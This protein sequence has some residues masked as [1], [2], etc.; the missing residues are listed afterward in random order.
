ML[1]D[2]DLLG[3]RARLFSLLGDACG[4]TG[5]VLPRI[6]LDPVCGR[7][8]PSAGALFP[9]E[10]YLV[11]PAGETTPS[12]SY[13]S[14]VDANVM[15][16]VEA[17]DI[18][19][20]G[21]A[22][23]IPAP[24]GALLCALVVAVAR[25]WRSMRKY[26]DRGYLYTCLDVAHATASI[27][28]AAEAQ[29]FAPTIFLRIRRRALAHALGLS[30]HCR[31]PQVVLALS[32]DADATDRGGKGGASQRMPSVCNL[33]FY[34]AEPTDEFEQRAW[35]GLRAITCY[36]QDFPP[37]QV[38]RRHSSLAGRSPA[39]VG[40]DT[41][42]S[43]TLW[44]GLFEAAPL[45]FSARG[46]LP[47]PLSVDA[48]EGALRDLDADLLLDCA[49]FDARS[50]VSLSL[51]ARRIDGLEPGIYRLDPSGAMSRAVGGS[52]T[53]ASFSLACMNQSVVENAAGLVV[54]HA[55][56]R[57]VLARRGRSGLCEL[58]FHAGQVAH[59][60]CVAAARHD[61]GITCIGGFDEQLI[62]QAVWLQSEDDAIYVIAIG[63]ADPEAVKLDRAAIAYAHGAAQ[64]TL[65]WSRLS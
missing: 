56:V 45:R 38:I 23:G 40:A 10:L 52:D 47:E 54:L 65:Q 60:L 55:P 44:R 4:Q 17:P 19:A 25:P 12:T 31:E 53:P 64:S 36:H 43:E 30:D 22:A 39:P 18:G 32:A 63:K 29:R 26:G 1:S 11:L 46:F 15:R 62:A 20:L 57:E 5:Q 49:D 9:Y 28:A 50:G 37:P 34:H 6:G 7:A 61:F 48:L 2:E 58:H 27:A 13:I 21:A 35:E 14:D 3:L 51:A 24:T 59:K 16:A 42:D 41:R 33:P 8:V